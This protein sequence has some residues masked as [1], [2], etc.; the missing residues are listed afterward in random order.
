MRLVLIFDTKVVRGT[1]V[2]QRGGWRAILPLIGAYLFFML[3]NFVPTEQSF[4]V[5]QR[6]LSFF[7]L[8]PIDI[9]N[10]A[11]F[12][13]IVLFLPYILLAYFS[14]VFFEGTMSRITVRSRIEAFE[15]EIE[16]I[17][18]YHNGH[19][20]IDII[21]TILRAKGSDTTTQS[22]KI[23]SIMI[24]LLITDVRDAIQRLCLREDIR[25]ALFVE[26]QREIDP[27]RKETVLS[28]MATTEFDK[29]YKQST[30]FRIP[31]RATSYQGFCGAAWTKRKPQCG[32]YYRGLGFRR[33]HRFFLYNPNDRRR[34]FLC[35]PILESD[36]ESAPVSAV[37]SIDS[38]SSL[39]FRLT[40]DLLFELYIATRPVQQIA[41]GY[42]EIL[43]LVD[44]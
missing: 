26:G 21:D 1:A 19:P 28:M 18:R 41:Q 11:L 32:A 43:K 44:N 37:L 31:Y 42:L 16:A 27:G 10:R 15:K 5:A 6:I 35:F 2:L 29:D 14:F 40:K 12:V 33:D 7:H 22:K 24:D 39:D 23:L 4:S 9:K 34:S 38:G 20:V 13:S 30:F 36:M 17:S 25:V 8:G 3:Q